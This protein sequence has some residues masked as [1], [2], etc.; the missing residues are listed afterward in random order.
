MPGPQT[1]HL[2]RRQTS[3]QTSALLRRPRPPTGRIVPS[4]SPERMKSPSGEK[5]TGWTSPVW[6]RSTRN[7]R[8]GS[9]APGVLIALGRGTDHQRRL[10]SRPLI[11]SP[12]NLAPPAVSTW[13]PSGA[14]ATAST[15]SVCADNLAALFQRQHTTAAP[16]DRRCPK[17]VAGRP[18]RTPAPSP[19]SCVLAGAR[20]TLPV[21]TSHS[22]I[23]WSW[24]PEATKRPSGLKATH[25]TGLACQP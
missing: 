11:H 9:T 4:Q 3:V 10:K 12:S 25:S 19:A 18:A 17:P 22:Q 21:V 5:A 23:W 7:F 20:A 15:P 13:R 6:P 2:S 1:C 8:G 14:N 24:P 16:N